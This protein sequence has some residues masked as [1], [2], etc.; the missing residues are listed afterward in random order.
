MFYV[1]RVPEKTE[2]NIVLLNKILQDTSINY[3]GCYD[4]LYKFGGSPQHVHCLLVGGPYQA[5]PIDHE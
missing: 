2:Q 1:K 5:P 3:L 4:Q